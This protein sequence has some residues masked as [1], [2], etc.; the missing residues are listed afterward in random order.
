[1]KR[2][3]ISAIILALSIS[4]TLTAEEK[5][6]IVTVSNLRM[7]ST[8]DLKGKVVTLLERGSIV[9]IFEESVKQLKVGDN[10]APWIRVRHTTHTGW[11][12]SGYVSTD[13]HCFDKDCGVVSWSRTIPK[14]NDGY[15]Y[16]TEISL[17]YKMAKKLS[18]VI[19]SPETAGY[20][21]SRNLKYLAIDEGTDG[22]GKISFY[23]VQDGKVIHSA[24]FS[25]RSIT[26]NGNKV[27]Y[28]SVLCMDDGFTVYEEQIFNNG[29]IVKTGIYGKGEYHVGV[30]TGGCRTYLKL[31]KKK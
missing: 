5:K 15:A 20:S 10:E 6:G 25:P 16:S 18:S 19:V 21:F 7:R 22:V 26:W 12:F 4:L 1:M 2:M 30:E 23:G 14:E 9:S 27:H 17:Y 31:L 3:I 11:L 28:H 13:F 8:P 24:S 29:K